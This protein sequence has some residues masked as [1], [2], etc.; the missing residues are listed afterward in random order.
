M[1]TTQRSG[2]HDSDT[3]ERKISLRKNQNLLAY[4]RRQNM[5]L[6]EGYLGQQ[7]KR[8]GYGKDGVN[9]YKK[10]GGG[11]QIDTKKMDDVKR[12]L[13]VESGRIK[14]DQDQ[15]AELEKFNMTDQEWKDSADK[16]SES[17]KKKGYKGDTG[18]FEAVKKF[19]DNAEKDVKS[20][21]ESL[22][23][24][25]QYGKTF[26]SMQARVQ[27][28]RDASKGAG[29][30]NKEQILEAYGMDQLT[31]AR[32][33]LDEWK[34]KMDLLKADPSA[35][36][37]DLLKHEQEGIGTKTKELATSIA[38]QLG[39]KDMTLAQM[40]KEGADMYLME[41]ATS[42]DFQ[43]I[44]DRAGELVA[45][46]VKN[47]EDGV[48]NKLIE[49]ENKVMLE[50]ADTTLYEDERVATK[51]ARTKNKLRGNTYAIK[52]TFDD[53]SQS[54]KYSGRM[55]KRDAE[56]NLYQI[57]QSFQD[58]TTKAFSALIDGT[59]SGK[60]A[61]KDLTDG[62][63]KMAQDM[64]LEMM[65]K[66]YIFNPMSNMLGGG[67]QGGLVGDK[68]VQRFSRGG[69]VK[70]GSGTKDD[71]SAL[72]SKGEYVVK[73]S[74]V[75]KY[76]MSFLNSL[77]SG[78]MPRPNSPDP[79]A[80]LSSLMDSHQS[81]KG[82]YAKFNL[83]NA[84]VYDSDTPQRGGSSGYAID[85]RLSRQGLSDTENPRNKFRMDKMQKLYDYWSNRDQELKDWRDSVDEYKTAKKKGMQRALLMA[86][87][88]TAMGAAF[89]PDYGATF[90]SQGTL[91][92]KAGLWS[93]GGYNKRD[94]IPS[95]LMGGEYVVSSDTVNRYGVDFFRNLNEGKMKAY[96][97][98]GL[99]GAE[100]GN[101][102]QASL[103]EASG[104]VN[105]VT[106][107]VNVD[108]GGGVTA[109]SSG[110]SNEEG[111]N[112]AIL[113]KDQVVKTLVNEKRQGGIL[114]N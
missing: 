53:I 19:L 57:S 8:H 46:Y 71:I 93:T 70:G 17:V 63:G 3:P 99:V 24:V 68:G 44:K 47:A 35:T 84:F 111:Q 113:I 66:R 91:G 5:Q 98:G 37:A 55:M 73:K 95:M 48:K 101:T 51:R 56:D 54:W 112:L 94:N 50:G 97:D 22:D 26:V 90:G 15:I 109:G 29:V 60:E 85:S 34:K 49:L 39:T 105:N 100:P 31:K 110:M 104:A 83:R 88:P 114:Y 10:V 62:I 30:F 82:A 87:V 38:N 18:D 64:L 78:D 27:E 61:F 81:N 32:E 96:A 6:G 9:I 106:I 1:G 7:A 33:A 92:Q 14:G 4:T 76:G 59:K 13:G 23:R 28:L 52:D 42:A 2:A 74:S 43:S 102:A 25:K 107:N 36:R 72:L 11:K 12:L 58:Q 16:L 75:N 41:D 45:Q 69:E 108:K 80:N 21:S 89:G 40:L 67:A 79:Q 20:F 103:D 77:N 65:I 86:A